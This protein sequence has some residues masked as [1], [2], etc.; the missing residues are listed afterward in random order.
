ME[1]NGNAEQ[2]RT[3]DGAT[4]RRA[5]RLSTLD[6]IFAVQY[7]TLTTATLLVGFLLALG[8]TAAQIGLVAMLPLLG[9][10]LQPLGAELVRRRG[11]WRKGVAVGA[12]LLDDLLWLVTLA[13]VALWPGRQAVVGVIAV[14]AIQQFV[15]AFTVVSWTSWISD[16]IPAALR[17][18][19]FGRRNFICNAL[20][21]ASAVAAGQF[22]DHVGHN[23]VW[24]FG[25]VIAVGMAF[26]LAS[27]YF[28]ARQPEP[29]PARNLEGRF[30]EQL[31]APLAHVNFRRY[32]FFGMAFGFAV[33]LCSPFFSVYML[34]D[35]RIDFG[36]VMVLAG[37]S[38]VTNLLGQRYWGPLSDR[39]GH[40]QVLRLTTLVVAFQ[41]FWWL[42]TAKAGAGFYLIFV[43]HALGGFTWG[44]YLL[45][46]A[47]LMM[48]LAPE[49]GKT[50]FFA[51][52]GA[53]GGLFGALGPLVGGLLAD[54][55]PAIPL[56]FLEPSGLLLLFFLSFALR[57]GAWG[58][59]RRVEEPVRKPPLRVTY[60]IRD[61][62][63][64]FNVTQGFSPL[65]HTFSE[66]EGKDDLDLDEALD[67]LVRREE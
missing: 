30:V 32:L 9:G 56:P 31:A 17:G 38:T 6:G 12:A 41:P 14:V 36:T 64:T 52:Q 29:F 42:F 61:A 13:L 15:T 43:L 51:V 45:A 2:E 37:I 49:T 4:I 21:A 20:G 22:V 44:G 33:Q 24:S 7:T 25:V 47:N 55:L 1:P 48:R 40:R 50:S 28:L 62:V 35:L 16:L 26:R 8:A 67:A 59:L 11:G 63:R 60:L 27:A 19:Y 34:R 58:L 23:A 46:N 54:A 39:F 65:L 53:L 57:L 10:L 5:M 3:I 18:R 66:D